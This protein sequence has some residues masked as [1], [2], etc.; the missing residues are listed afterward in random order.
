MIKD[1][2]A[3]SG[4]LSAVK[5]RRSIRNFKLEKIE[6]VEGRKDNSCRLL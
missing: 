3:E 2:Y 4:T 6:C 5:F 1:I